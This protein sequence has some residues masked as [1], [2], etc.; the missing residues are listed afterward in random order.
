MTLF[1]LPL[2]VMGIISKIK[3]KKPADR[4]KDQQQQKQKKQA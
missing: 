1:H 3:T 2:S 4:R